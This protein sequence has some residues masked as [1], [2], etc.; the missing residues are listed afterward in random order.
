MSWNGVGLILWSLGLKFLSQVIQE[1]NLSQMVL[2]QV[3]GNRP[4]GVTM[5]PW[6]MG[7]QLVWDGWLQ[8][9][10]MFLVE[11]TKVEPSDRIAGI[12]W[13]AVEFYRI[14]CITRSLAP[15]AK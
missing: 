9:G 13:N 3:T 4:D 6:K 5:I 11:K 1:K 15:F 7:K 12:E 8:I 14:C 2:G 10:R